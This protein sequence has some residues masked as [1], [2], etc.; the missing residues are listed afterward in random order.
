MKPSVKEI[1]E[2]TDIAVTNLSSNGGYLNPEQSDRF[3]DLVLNQPTILREVRTVRMSS[4]VRLIEKVGFDS[5]ILRAAP[6]SGTTLTA[7]ERAAPTTSKVTLTTKELMAEVHLPYDVLEDNIEHSN[8]E[9]TI[10]RNMASRTA[11]D[12]EELLITGDT[13]SGDTYLATMDGL[14]KQ[15]T[16]HVV[17]VGG[18]SSAMGKAILKAGLLLMPDK[19]LR[20]RSA[21]RFWVSPANELHYR[22]EVADRETTLGDNTLEGFRPTYAYGIP[23]VSAA[24]MPADKCILTHPQNIIWG[25]QRQIS[26]ETDRDIRARTYII[27]L[28]LRVDMKFETEDAVVEINGINEAA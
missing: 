27:V 17:D 25:V 14:I 6:A 20:N 16:S 18:G 10:L 7:G 28:T 19:Y 3:I 26:V 2:K 21:F 9:E 22:D 5:R 4:P 15:A 8:F 11:T 12:L 24:L 1:L 13:A 23:V